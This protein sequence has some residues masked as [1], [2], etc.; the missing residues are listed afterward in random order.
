MLSKK[1]LEEHLYNKFCLFFFSSW[2]DASPPHNKPN[3]LILLNICKLAPHWI[4]TIERE[5]QSDA[6]HYILLITEIVFHKIKE[7]FLGNGDK[8]SSSFIEQTS[9]MLHP[10]T[11]GS[12]NKGDYLLFQRSTINSIYYTFSHSRVHF[13]KESVSAVETTGGKGK[14]FEAEVPAWLQYPGKLSVWNNALGNKSTIQNRK[15]EMGKKEQFQALPLWVFYGQCVLRTPTP[16]NP[17][18]QSC[19]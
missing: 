5:K 15:R 10:S 6:S 19:L 2:H 16:V 3:A 1:C 14:V 11:C 8:S 13:W 12:A 18:R 9:Q 4:K 17:G 7:D